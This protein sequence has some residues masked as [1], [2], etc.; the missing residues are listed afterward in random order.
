MEGTI[1]VL[2]LI[3]GSSLDGLDVALCSFAIAKPGDQ[4][5]K[6]HYAKTYDFPP[7]LLDGLTNATT[8]AAK[9]LFALEH[10][11]STFCADVI[12]QV[13]KEQEESIDYICSHGHT[14]FHYPQ[15]GWTLQ[16]GKGALWLS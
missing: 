5:W 10:Q 13:K 3:S 12:N 4:D 9:D 2:G 14:V 7:A 15:D 6:C 1:T 11:F 16:I 8:L